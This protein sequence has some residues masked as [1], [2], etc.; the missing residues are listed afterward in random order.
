MLYRFYILNF[1][2]PSFKN[3]FELSFGDHLIKI[4]KNEQYDKKINDLEENSSVMET[5]IFEINSQYNEKDIVN[6]IQRVNNLFSICRSNIIN[7]SG[8]SK[9]ND[10]GKLI[11]HKFHNPISCNFSKFE[12]IQPKY[13]DDT[14][15]FVAQ[16]MKLY[17]KLNSEYNLNKITREFT[18]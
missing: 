7:Y 8:Y 10:F 11:E 15:S 3:D 2:F 4:Y 18:A 17:D 14:I 13:F 1:E 5:A 16:G 9:F 6:L 12:I